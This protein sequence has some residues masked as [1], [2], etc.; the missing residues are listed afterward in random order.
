MTNLIVQVLPSIFGWKVVKR[1]IATY[2]FQIILLC[3][4]T[5]TDIS[6]LLLYAIINHAVI[7]LFDTLVVIMHF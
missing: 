5:I 7:R 2:T 6:M 1:P 4:Q 3:K